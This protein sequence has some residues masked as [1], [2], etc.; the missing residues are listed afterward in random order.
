MTR[1]L[2]S[3]LVTR[4]KEDPQGLRAIA[5]AF[6]KRVAELRASPET[7]RQK[8]Y[9]DPT[10]VET[11][12]PDT[13]AF[14]LKLLVTFEGAL[15]AIARRPGTGS[16]EA[17]CAL[18]YYLTID[19]TEVPEGRPIDELDFVSII[20]V[21]YSDPLCRPEDLHIVTALNLLA[22]HYVT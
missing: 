10:V 12:L 2:F 17:E 3:K 18:R 6:Q 20:Y 1:Q 11:S 9:M 5:V 21:F 4:L 15:R 14:V 16:A 22:Q 19:L 13:M 7:H 8:Q